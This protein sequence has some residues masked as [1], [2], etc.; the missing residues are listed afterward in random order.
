MTPN[1]KEAGIMGKKSNTKEPKSRQGQNKVFNA[2]KEQNELL[3]GLV[4]RLTGGELEPGDPLAQRENGS[5]DLQLLP[6][7]GEKPKET[8]KPKRSEQPNFPFKVVDGGKKFEEQP[9]FAPQN[10]S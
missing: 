2:Y 7:G 8:K 4:M 1:H 9:P 3:W 6:G 5:P 10:P